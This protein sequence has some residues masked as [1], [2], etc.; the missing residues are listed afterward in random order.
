MEILY[1]SSAPSK[2]QYNYIESMVKKENV[3]NNY[4][5]PEAS[6]K[7]HN[8][9]MDGL[10]TNGANICSLVGRSVSSK[11]HRGLFWKSAKDKKDKIKYN[12]LFFINLPI[13]K[14]L[15]ICLQVLIFGLV[16]LL[17]NKNNEDKCIIIDGAYITLIPIVNLMTFFIKANKISIICDVYSYMAD[18]NDARTKKNSLHKFINKI[19]KK[20]YQKIDGFIFLTE[21]MSKLPPFEN[22]PYT[23]IEGIVDTK[24]QEKTKSENYIMYAGALRAEY[25]VKR[26]VD[27]FHSTTNSEFE[28]L[29]FGNGN[30]VDNIKE[31]SKEDSR[32]KYMGKKSL[33]EIYEYERNAFLLVNPRLTENDFVKYSFPSKNMEYMTSGTPLLTGKLPGMPKEYYDYVYFI[34]DDTTTSLKKALEEIFLRSKQELKKFGKKAQNFICELKNKNVQTKKIVELNSEINE[35]KEKESIKP[36]FRF[37]GINKY[38]P[39]IFGAG[40]FLFTILLFMF[41]PYDWNLNNSIKIYSFLLIAFLLLV[42]GYIVALKTFKKVRKQKYININKVFL[43]CLIIFFIIYFPTCYIRTGKW[44]PDLVNGIL[45]AG[46]AYQM[47]HASN[48]SIIEYIRIFLSP[49]IALI[50]PIYILFFS[51]LSKNNKIFGGI[52][53]ILTLFLGI[54][55]GVSKQYADFLIQVFIVAGLLFFSNDNAKTLKSKILIIFIVFL[56]LLSFLFYYKAIMSN[57]ISTDIQTELKDNNSELEPDIPSD[58]EIND[59]MK[60]YSSFGVATLKEDYFLINQLPE[61]LK[62]S[63]LYLVSYVT[64]GYKGL[65]LA[66]D[67]EFTT[68]YG[69]GFSE[70]LRHNISRFCNSD[71][72]EQ[73]YS[74]TYMYK[75]EADGWKTLDVWSSFFIYPASDIGFFLTLILVFFIGYLF[76]YAWKDALMTGNI[77]AAAVFYNLIIMIFYFSANNQLFHTGEN[78]VASS[79]I[80][81]IYFI[82]IINRKGETI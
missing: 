19:V 44:Y 20:Q 71:F 6:F 62:T 78:F 1:I 29:L 67:K 35:K 54:A 16:W 22:K 27:A 38:L 5:M 49:F 14:H 15:L 21:E 69:L 10:T 72:E 81:I 73:I 7:F 61:S 76:G 12:H 11:T 2:K 40:F 28:L 57:R 58:E 63:A 26:L 70:F 30:Y 65:S 48:G 17:K 32:I 18:V 42:A 77:F 80:L 47:S 33:K 50:T 31:I 82:Q 37:K 41:G 59:T 23:I 43:I 9:I 8:L 51:K 55:S 13:I 60:E 4:G 79:L 68:S 3:N 56:S 66:M 46:K 25:G 24:K 64:H 74:R 45:N 53:I 39:L 34:E 52:A 36:I 75:I